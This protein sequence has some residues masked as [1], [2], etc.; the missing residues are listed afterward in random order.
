MIFDYLPYQNRE[1][2]ETR[3]IRNY[4]IEN[5]SNISKIE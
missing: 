1:Q 4:F 5:Y 3:E 2:Y